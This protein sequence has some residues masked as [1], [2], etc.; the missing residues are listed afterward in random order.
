MAD[1]DSSHRRHEIIE[2]LS[3]CQEGEIER[4]IID[5]SI[6]V[7]DERQS[8]RGLVEGDGVNLLNI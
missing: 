5:K 4:S 3:I 1:Y 8:Y 7:F 6:H 2:Q